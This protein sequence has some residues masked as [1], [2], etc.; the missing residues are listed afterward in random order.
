M[1]L[2]FNDVIYNVALAASSDFQFTELAIHISNPDELV[3][4]INI[5]FY[6]INIMST[7]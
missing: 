4:D 1:Y 6:E 7:R 2:Y 3:N 5:I